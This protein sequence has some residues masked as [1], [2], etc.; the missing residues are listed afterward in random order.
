MQ[1]WFDAC[2]T[3]PGALKLTRVCGG[4]QPEA[5]WQN[6]KFFFIY[7]LFSVSFISLHTMVCINA[8]MKLC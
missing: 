6:A 2:L 8:Q 3:L 5:F 1:H 4:Q 7:L